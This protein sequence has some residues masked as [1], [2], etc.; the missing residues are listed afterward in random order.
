L[1]GV[2]PFDYDY[3]TIAELE[4]GRRF[5][6][7]STMLSMSSWQH[8]RTITPDTGGTAVVHDRVTFQPRVALRLTAPLLA[9]GIGAFFSHRHRRLRRHCAVS[10]G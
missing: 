5:L 6:E 7:Q 3:L 8:E 9:V 4:P 2:V 1:F 10:P